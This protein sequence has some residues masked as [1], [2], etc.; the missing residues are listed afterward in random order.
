MT[1]PYLACSSYMQGLLT[2]PWAGVLIAGLG[3]CMDY[4]LASR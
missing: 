3:V 4:E 2:Y 1:T